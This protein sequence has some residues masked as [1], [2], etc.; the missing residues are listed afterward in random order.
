M[1]FISAQLKLHRKLNALKMEEKKSAI[2]ND[3]LSLAISETTKIIVWAVHS[4]E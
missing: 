3:A 1:P 4:I 2:F